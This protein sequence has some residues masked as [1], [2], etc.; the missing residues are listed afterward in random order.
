MSVRMAAAARLVP[1]LIG[2]FGRAVADCT[3]LPPTLMQTTLF[4]LRIMSFP[5]DELHA[6]V[7]DVLQR[8]VKRLI[9][10]SPP[11]VAEAP[12]DP[13]VGLLCAASSS[14]GPSALTGIAAWG[15][16]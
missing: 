15:V 4:A 11:A 6:V 12:V 2:A 9:L 10:D 5:G 3:S 8:V 13:V 7:R 16:S 14:Q 1:E